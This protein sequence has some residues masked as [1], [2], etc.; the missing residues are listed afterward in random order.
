M[1]K[2]PIVTESNLPKWMK[3]DT[4]EVDEDAVQNSTHISEFSHEIKAKLSWDAS[5]PFKGLQAP[6][7]A[8][9]KAEEDGIWIPDCSL[10]MSHDPRVCTSARMFRD[11]IRGSLNCQKLGLNL[12]KMDIT[13]TAAGAEE[14]RLLH[15]DLWKT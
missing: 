9:E 11:L 6:R 7:N 13:Y 14:G 2:A 12:R 1:G 5:V 15:M 3:S 4:E 10:I 8:L